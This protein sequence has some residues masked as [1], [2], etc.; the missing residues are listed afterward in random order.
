MRQGG[1]ALAREVAAAAK[2]A[3]KYGSILDGH[4]VLSRSIAAKNHYPAIDVLLSASRVMRAVTSKGGAGRGYRDNMTSIILPAEDILKAAK[5]A[6][7]AKGEPAKKDAAK[8]SKA[9][10]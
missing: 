5:Q 7:E 1:V 8:E 10:K 4:I 6:P 3:L 9:E 2:E